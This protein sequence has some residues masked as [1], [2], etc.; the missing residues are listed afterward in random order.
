MI[1]RT[2]LLNQ[3]A[4]A[5]LNNNSVV[6]DNIKKYENKMSKFK[7]VNS[8]NFTHYKGRQSKDPRI[9]LFM[10]G[11]NSR[12]ALNS[13]NK[14]MLETNHFDESFVPLVN[15]QEERLLRTAGPSMFKS[16]SQPSLMSGNTPG[17]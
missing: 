2:P 9:P 17:K 6:A 15:P 7:S 3:K 8:P 10:D 12:M 5:Y 16:R 1:A 4:V 14:K 13:L 11:V